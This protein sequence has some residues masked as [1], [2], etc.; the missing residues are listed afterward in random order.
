MSDISNESDVNNPKNNNN[1]SCSTVSTATNS[2]PVSDLEV[3]TFGC[4][5]N[6]Y[7]S[8]VIRKLGKDADLKNIVII[9][10]CS[11]TGEAF[12]RA[13]QT[14]RKIKK[15]RPN[16]K[17]VVTGCA[18]QIES[19]V[20][21][22]MAE[23]DQVIGN[24]D[25][26]KKESYQADVPRLLITD[27]MEA[28]ETAN[29]L[30]QGFEGHTRAF[31]QIQN[32]CDNR[33]SFC[34]IPFARGNN[35]SVKYQ[36]IIDQIKVLIQNGYKEIILTGINI[37]SYGKDFSDK[38]ALS[39]GKLVSKILSEFPEL[40]RL[41][42]SS[43]DPMDIDNNL[44]E[45]IKKEDR[46]MPHIHL[47][48]QAGDNTILRKMR[49]KHKRE[50]IILLCEKLKKNRPDIVLGAD[51]ITGFPTETDEMFQNTEDLVKRCGFIFLHVFPYS[52]R[53][54]TAA[55]KMTQVVGSIRKERAAI[56][57]EIGEKS[58]RNYLSSRI[59]KTETV[60]VEKNN[61]GHSEYFTTIEVTSSK[62]LE[63]QIVNVIIDS[64]EDGKLK[65]KII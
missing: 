35:R 16:V 61:T 18:A 40:H 7:E 22:S 55:A 43:L 41:R 30:I 1:T 56:L 54:G 23:V 62:S 21:D 8:E 44:L 39:L 64:V 59:E 60:L 46:L 2:P 50:D 14:I 37:T 45:A 42:L 3:I 13:K 63:N 17:I 58:I 65:G 47:S 33:C 19:G 24:E 49:R 34:I 36:E 12:K 57:R 38:T 53:T 5:L 52:A 28:T 26:L 10:T 4:R 48:L 6:I 9:N 32:G 29:H 27:I 25:K 31:V 51:I 11:V 20:F 15:T